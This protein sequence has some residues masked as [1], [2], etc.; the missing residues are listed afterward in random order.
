MGTKKYN[1][2]VP[3]HKAHEVKS[4]FMELTGKYPF[5]TEY[6]DDIYIQ[7]ELTDEQKEQA[8]IRLEM[9]L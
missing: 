4:M 8:D 6:W 3:R 9:I 1:I 5:S 2:V 7:T